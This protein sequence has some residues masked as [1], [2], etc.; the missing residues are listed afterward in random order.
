MVKWG[1]NQLTTNLLSNF[2]FN[3]VICQGVPGQKNENNIMGH[4][5]G[6]LL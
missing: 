4:G 5:K 1:T 3:M 6:D 2:G